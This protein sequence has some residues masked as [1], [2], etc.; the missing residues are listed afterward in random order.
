LLTHPGG[1]VSASFSA[2][3]VFSGPSTGGPPDVSTVDVVYR[4]FG[5]VA[6][7]KSGIGRKERTIN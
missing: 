1:D 7:R 5:F 3:L 6:E 2:V 4:G